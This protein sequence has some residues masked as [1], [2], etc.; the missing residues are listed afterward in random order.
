MSDT[1]ARGPDGAFIDTLESAQRDAE[2]ARL[3]SRGL[4]YRQIASELGYFD[5]SGARKA[6]QR[7][8]AAI[9]AEG[10]EEVRQLQLQQL[11]YLTTKA[12][13]VLERHHVTVS[14][15]R[16]IK[17]DDQPL[18]DDGP[19]LQAIDR[20]LK[21]Q[22]RRAKLLGLDAPTQHQVVTLDAIEAEIARL[23]AQFADGVEAPEAAGA[24]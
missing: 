19:V 18:E 23:T 16:L 6:V 10:A 17:V 4:S 24:S 14:N 11:D 21:I 3:R 1:P 8:L 7:A 13:E 2:A 5:G 20:L 9:R 22:E 15:G 12:L